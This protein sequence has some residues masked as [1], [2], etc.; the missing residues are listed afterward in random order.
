ML[1][2]R[3]ISLLFNPVFIITFLPFFLD[4][5]TSSNLS[6][7]INWTIY[8]LVFLGAVGLF[9]TY[10]VYKK[11]FTDFDV[12]KREQRPLLFLFFTIA[13]ILYTLGLL[14]FKGPWI[15][16]VNAVGILF[17][18]FLVSLI[19]LKIKASLHVATLSALASAIA[20]VYRGYYYFIFLIIPLVAWSRIKT[21]RHTLPETIVG[22][23]VGV[24]LSLFMYYIIKLAAS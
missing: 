11:I 18:V 3:I 14:I 22:G 23:F 9:V 15:L 5:K 4:Y 2:A 8:T 19:N 7:S 12:S 1:I 16:L 6:L 17:G 21:K 13:G 20:V 24:F 10:G